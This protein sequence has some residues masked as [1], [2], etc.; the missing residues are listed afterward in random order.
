[1]DG[2]APEVAQEVAMLFQHEYI[3]TCSGKQ[4]TEHH[5][6]RASPGN[7]AACLNCVGHFSHRCPLRAFWM[8]LA[9]RKSS[10]GRLLK[11]IPKW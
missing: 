3:D 5:P 8:T 11:A 4:K 2:V 10:P 9:I 1:M 6:G 7:A